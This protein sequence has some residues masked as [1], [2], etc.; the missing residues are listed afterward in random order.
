MRSGGGLPALARD[1]I[2]DL[3]RLIRLEVELAAERVKVQAARKVAA[4]AAGAGA[5]L[6]LMLGLLFGLATS[7]AALAIVLPLWAALAIVTGA[8]VLLG[9]VLSLLALTG[10]KAGGGLIP[11]D[12][13]RQIREDLRWLR[14]QS[15]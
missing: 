7:A 1:T 6:F 13:K 15:S 3:Q 10:L 4:V 14:E 9:G 11:E 5:A 12:A 2:S 8:A